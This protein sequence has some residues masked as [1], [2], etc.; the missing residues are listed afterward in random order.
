MW[1]VAVVGGLALT[2]IASAPEADA[3]TRGYF[4]RIATFDVTGRVAEI[5]AATSDGNTLI[6]TDADAKEVG[7]I[8]INDPAAPMEIGKLST[9]GEP[10]SVANVPGSDFALVA[11]DPNELLV[12]NTSTRTVVRTI[13]LTGQPDAVAVSPN[14]RYAAVVMEN[15]RDESLNGGALP[16]GNPGELVIVDL[17][18]APAAWTTRMV[19]LTGIADNFPTDPEPEFVDINSSNIAAVTLQENNHVVLVDLPTGAIVSD[20]SAGFSRHAA[21]TVRNGD[22]KFDGALLDARREPDAIA[23][24][25]NGRLITANEG[26]YSVTPGPAGFIGGRDFTIFRSN[27]T[28]VYEPGVSLE[29]AAARIGHYPEARSNSKGIEVEGAEVGT[30][31]SN[32]FAFIGSERGNFVAVYRIN[33]ESKPSLHQILPTGV[34]PEG[35]LAIPGRDLFVSANEGNGTL[36]IYQYDRR[37]QAPAYPQVSSKTVNWG[38]LSGLAPKGSNGLWAVADSAFTSSRIYRLGLRGANAEILQEIRLPGNFDLEG[39]TVRPQGGFWVVSEGAATAA[40]R[41][42]LLLQVNPDGTVAQ[43][44]DL[45]QAIIDQQVQFGF[46]GVATSAD[47]SQVYV[48]FQR[49]WT[50]DPAG[51]VKIGRYTPATQAWAFYH[52]PLDAA[53]AITGAWVGLSELVR[54]NDTTFAVV[55]RD[56]QSRDNAQ[57]KRIYTFSIAGVTPVAAGQTPPRL[58]KTLVRDLLEADDLRLEKLEGLTILPNRRVVAVTDNDGVGETRLLQLGRLFQ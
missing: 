54:V 46:E 10:T 44:V 3:A 14:G 33:N 18:G 37:A 27:G 12:V 38:A 34:S 32:V 29:Q 30:F 36:S 42:N 56:N 50:G 9:A 23:W 4:D 39:I 5:V 1:A 48:A 6:Y 11:V 19:A 13:P 40:A 51:F 47:G 7:F 53:P 21:D 31:H 17:V 2:A 25:P 49:E 57:T 20:W 28:V 58:T 16:Q 26:D 41:K 22:I 8:G 43:T 45:P 24:T 35:L 15:Q 55:E 52:Y